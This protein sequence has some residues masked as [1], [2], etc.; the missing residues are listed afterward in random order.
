[1]T[2]HISKK[3]SEQSTGGVPL[4]IQRDFQANLRAALKFVFLSTSVDIYIEN[5]TPT[6]NLQTWDSMH[7]LCT[8]FYAQKVHNLRHIQV[9][10]ITVVI[11]LVHYRSFWSKFQSFLFFLNHFHQMRWIKFLFSLKIVTFWVVRVNSNINV[12]HNLIFLYAEVSAASA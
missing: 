5:P 8:Q 2:G 12:M 1:M 9:W 4:S 10:K 3:L 6:L 11:L 7:G